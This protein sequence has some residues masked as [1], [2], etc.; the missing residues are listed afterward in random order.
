M[1]VLFKTVQ[2]VNPRDLTA[3]KKFYA[4][5]IANGTTDLNELAALV[6]SQCTVSKADC[7][8]V[9]LAL[10]ANI[11]RELQNG[12]IVR[13][14]ELGSYQ[15]G[16]SAEGVTSSEEVNAATIK[17]AK[18]NFRPGNGLKAMLKTLHYKKAQDQ[19]A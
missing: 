2:R 15:I 12:R 11:V 14:G 9:L 3:Q 6:A 17:K 10:E 1:S 7:Y 13:L 19:A 4:T 16:I 8:A 18:I 5:N